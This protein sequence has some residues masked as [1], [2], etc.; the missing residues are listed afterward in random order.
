ME[1][2]Q[3]RQMQ[4]LPLDVK[5]LKTKQRIREWYDYWQGAVYVSFSRGK[6]STVLLDLVRALYTDVPA[7]FFDTGLEY[8]ELRKFVK[9]FDD[10]VWL[11]PKRNFR[12]VIEEHGYPVVSKRVARL[13]KNIS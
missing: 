7:V 11:K 9:E 8:P 4:S 5:I 6:D 13:A 1:D 12:Q 10:V 3:L 2:W